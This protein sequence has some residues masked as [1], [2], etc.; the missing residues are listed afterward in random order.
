MTFTD[1][2]LICLIV[3][4]IISAYMFW[5]SKKIP[6]DTSAADSINI[7][8]G[9]L[10]VITQANATLQQS[11]TAQLQNQ[12]GQLTESLRQQAENTG[13]KLNDLQT[14]LAVIDK[15]QASLNELAQQTTRLE[16]VLANK[17]ARGAYGEMQLENL[18]KQ[19]LPPNA[20]QFQAKLSN[21][22]RPDCLL[23]LPNP[24]GPI[25]IDAKFPL[26]AWY[27]MGD[28]V[29]DDTKNRARKKLA[30]AM[31]KHVDDIA[32]K[33]LLAGETAESAILF[34][35]SESI[36][37]EFHTNLTTIVENSFK[38]R[39]YIASPTTLMAT[40]NTVRAVLRD[41]KMREQAAVIQ[42]E[43]GKLLLDVDRLD[44]RVNKLNQHFNQAERDIQEITTSTRKI[45]QRGENIIRIEVEDDNKADA[46][47]APERPRLPDASS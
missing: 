35:P 10:E 13:T 28:A 42:T 19:M 12:H 45:T 43:I 23:L 7:L 11:I 47:E 30:E 18:V 15:A 6:Q 36:Y 17:Q 33:Y 9:Q 40:L 31:A 25:V 20:Y 4:I 14:R 3:V 46:I 27:E 44:T 32:R 16:N 34:L 29:D 22:A 39:V 37:A 26:E 38:K 41:V 2:L 1:I 21:D 5:Q 8:K 24:P